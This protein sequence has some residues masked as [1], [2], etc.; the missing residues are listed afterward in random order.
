MDAIRMIMQAYI[1]YWTWTLNTTSNKHIHIHHPQVEYFILQTNKCEVTSDTKSWSQSPFLFTLLNTDWQYWSWS[2]SCSCFCSC[3]Y[4]CFCFCSCSCSS[5]CSCSCS[6]SCSCSCSC[7]QTG[8]FVAILYHRWDTFYEPTGDLCLLLRRWSRTRRG[9][10]TSI[11]S[12]SRILFFL[13]TS[14]SPLIVWVLISTLKLRPR[15]RVGRSG[16]LVGPGW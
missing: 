5:S 9:S 13:V 14:F 12:R 6:S 16:A 1:K 8:S 4:S 3:F 11:R 15:R 2:L 10:T 7:S